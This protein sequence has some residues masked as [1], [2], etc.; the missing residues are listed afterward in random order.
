MYLMIDKQVQ[1]ILDEI[2]DEMIRLNH[3]P[4]D[5]TTPTQARYYHKEARKFFSNSSFEDVNT[6]DTYAE[7]DGHKIPIRI[8]TPEGDGP[9]PILVYFHGGGWVFSDIDG[10]D[11]VCNYIAKSSNCVVVSAGYRLA[12]EFKY[13]IP[14]EDAYTAFQWA[15]DN[16]DMLNGSDKVAI[17]GE[18]AGANLAASVALKLRDQSISQIHCQLLITPVIQHYFETDSY[19]E[20]LQ[21]NLS[22]EKMKWFWDFYLEDS[23]QGKE[24]YASPILG[25]SKDLPQALIY[26]AE[27]DPLKDEG[28]LYAKHLETNNVIVQYRCFNRLVH[29]FIHMAEKSKVAKEALDYICKDFHKAMYGE[30]KS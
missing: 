24:P 27:L 11:Y 17:G 25:S 20:G 13:P 4:L 1:Q 7:N 26:T 18:S 23:K 6:R 15:L 22:K 2:R 29:C 21:Y 9:F 30:I 14:L 12:P 3:P 19:N 8:Y 5:Q 28:M 10:S 16:K